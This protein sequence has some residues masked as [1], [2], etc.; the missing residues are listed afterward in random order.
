MGHVNNNI[1]PVNARRLTSA[2][3]IPIFG[4]FIE[5]DRENQKELV[6]AIN[7]GRA[8]YNYNAS[9]YTDHKGIDI[10]FVVCDSSEN[11][12]FHYNDENKKWH[13]ERG[14]SGDNNAQNTQ[15]EINGYIGIMVGIL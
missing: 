9:T 5:D 8:E 12:I 10:A 11:K 1:Y 2:D 3:L 14:G 7:S 4:S 15:D 13:D 6:Y